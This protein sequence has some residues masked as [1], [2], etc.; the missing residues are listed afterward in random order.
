MTIPEGHPMTD[1]YELPPLPSDIQ[2]AK[3]LLRVFS[4]ERVETM[5]QEY[6]RLAVKQERERAA[7]ALDLS[8]EQ[9]DMILDAAKVPEPPAGWREDYDVQVVRAI[10]AAI[11]AG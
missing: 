8:D 9:I 11:R 7:K 6:A 3:D 4:P 10:L 1:T 5:M 2:S